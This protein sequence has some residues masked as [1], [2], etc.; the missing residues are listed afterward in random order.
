MQTTFIGVVVWIVKAIVFKSECNYNDRDGA[1]FD[2]SN[3][4]GEGD[5]RVCL[6]LR[7]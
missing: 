6:S 3:G 5:E 2:D 7:K 1:L 4:N